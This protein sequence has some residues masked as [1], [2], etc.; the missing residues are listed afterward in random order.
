MSHRNCNA[1]GAHLTRWR[2]TNVLRLRDFADAPGERCRK[3]ETD[4]RVQ[5]R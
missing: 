1:G 5:Q 4:R 3:T 2:D